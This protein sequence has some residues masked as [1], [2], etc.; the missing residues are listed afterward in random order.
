M[1]GIVTAGM[2]GAGLQ[3]VGGLAQ[4]A[5]GIFGKKKRQRE[6]NALLAQRPVYKI[7]KEIGQD[8]EMNRNLVNA[9]LDE[10]QDMK[11]ALMTHQSNQVQ[12]AQAAS[13]SLEDMLAVGAAAGASTEDAL[14]Q[15]RIAGASERAKRRE[16]FSGSLMNMAEA[17]DQ[18][19]KLN[20]LDPFNQKVQMTMANNKASREMVFGGLSQAA[21]GVT[22]FGTAGNEAGFKTGFFKSE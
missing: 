22:N 10:Q 8:L 7:P 14:I 11:N 2:V 13:G 5:S 12:R 4:M 18:A 6:I 15:N 3:A 21:A 17:R 19:F 1:A 20:E 16:N 9:R